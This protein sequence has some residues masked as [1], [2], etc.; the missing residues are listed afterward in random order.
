MRVCVGHISAHCDNCGG[1]DFQPLH[2]ESSPAHE[3]VCFTCGARTTRRALLMQIANETV[4]RA[5]TF[6]EISKKARGQLRKR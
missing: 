4:K 3:L 1:Q 6:I 5:E 2:A